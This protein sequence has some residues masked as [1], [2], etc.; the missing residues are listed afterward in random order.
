MIN[1]HQM[2]QKVSLAVSDL[3][4]NGGYLLPEQAGAFIQKILDQSTF[5]QEVNYVELKTPQ[6]TY[7]PKISLGSSILRAD[8]DNN[9][10]ADADKVRM[11]N[12]QFLIKPFDFKAQVEIPYKTLRDNIEQEKLTEIILGYVSRGVQLDMEKLLIHANPAAANVP[13][14]V[15][16]IPLNIL[17][18]QKGLLA[19][20]NG[21]HVVDAQNNEIS[22]E[23]LSAAVKAMPDKYMALQ[24]SKFYMNRAL[25]EDFRL[26]S[27]DKVTV[28]P[29][30]DQGKMSYSG[31]G[32]TTATFLPRDTIL[33]L[34]PKLFYLGVYSQMSLK[35]FDDTQ[36]G[37]H[38]FTMRMSFGFGFEEQDAVV[39]IMNVKEKTL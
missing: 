1:E 15:G 9:R 6:E 19:Y 35:Y 28:A 11:A 5:L 12:S 31:V 33:M 29:L 21:A 8:N 37:L 7:Y 13:S 34:N 23:I 25:E 10:L 32:V 36:A 22:R 39:K 2:S 17:Q 24:N 30:V 27:W 3:T 38:V 14:I 18:S 4:Q 20:A 16:D 26:A